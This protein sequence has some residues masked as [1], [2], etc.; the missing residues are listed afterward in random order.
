MPG[1]H[2][3]STTDQCWDA[4][5]QL[6]VGVGALVEVGEVVVEVVQAEECLG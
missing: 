5:V 3:R 6:K 2:R 4:P 1:T